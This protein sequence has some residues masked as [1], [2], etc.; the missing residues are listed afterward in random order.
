MSLPRQASSVRTTVIVS[1]HVATG[2][3]GGALAGS[4]GRAIALGGLLHFLG[5]RVPHHDIP[6]Q[7]FELGSG[8]ALIGVLAA[9]RGPTSP[10]VLGAIGA[11]APDLEHLIPLPKPGGRKLFPSHRIDGWHRDGGLPAWVQLASAGVLVALVVAVG[12]NH[13]GSARN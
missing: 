4:R 9:T 13:R 6:S 8:M 2:A 5:D 11:S 1:L 12:R 7:W 10:E 3:V